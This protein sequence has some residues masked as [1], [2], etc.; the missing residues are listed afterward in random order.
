[1]N[2]REAAKYAAMVGW[3][4]DR[5]GRVAASARGGRTVVER[6]GRSHMYKLALR[7]AE[8]R[9]R[10][11]DGESERGSARSQSI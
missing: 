8:A 11:K 5:P 4:K 1:M 9:R 2:R 7:S 6:Y 3:E 10:R